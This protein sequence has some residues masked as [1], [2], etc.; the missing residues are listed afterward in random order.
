M[1][2]VNEK[3]VVRMIAVRLGPDEDL[4]K[5]I[6]NACKEY[7]IRD[8]VV[9]SCIGSLKHVNVYNFVPLGVSGE[10]IAYGYA[11]EAQA[12]G[13]LQGVMELC[14][15]KG[16]LHVDETGEPSGDLFVTFSNAAGT[17][18]GGRLGEGTLVKL[19]S[20]IVI[21]ELR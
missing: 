4:L 7:G 13:D 5:G 14:S 1:A 20:E 18:L 12:W 2:A 8:A 21:G 19:T 15:A 10:E 6:L 9:L 16:V 17:V 11:P 3:N